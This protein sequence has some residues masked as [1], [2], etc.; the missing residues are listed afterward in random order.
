MALWWSR[1]DHSIKGQ[2][3]Y[4]YVGLHEGVER[5]A[6]LKKELVALV[7]REIGAFAAP[8]VLHWAPGEIFD[9]RLSH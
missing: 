7:R 5:S 3:I 6:Q 8:D 4:A 1:Y 9:T 2:G